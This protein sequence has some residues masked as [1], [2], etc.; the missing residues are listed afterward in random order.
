MC[1]KNLLEVNRAAED[2]LQLM[3]QARITEALT[4]AA[5][6]GIPLK[7]RYEHTARAMVAA[8]QALRMKFAASP[9]YRAEFLDEP[10]I[11][12]APVMKHMKML[13]PLRKTRLSLCINA[14]VFTP[15]LCSETTSSSDDS[16]E[17]S[18]TDSSE[19]VDAP[20]EPRPRLCHLGDRVVG[21]LNVHVPQDGTPT[22]YYINWCN[23]THDNLLMSGEEMIKAFGNLECLRVGMYF[24]C[25][26]AHVPEDGKIHPSGA[27]PICVPSPKNNMGK[28]RRYRQRRTSARPAHYSR[29]GPRSRRGG[30]PGPVSYR[31]VVAAY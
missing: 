16:S 26:V 14:Q 18:S 10:V 4:D 3:R 1:T 2:H 28:R 24:Q 30:R 7:S 25:T 27:D 29:S 31:S 12:E 13:H 5:Q 6:V 11:E 15:S 23:R 20:Q 17:R 21:R 9:L 22:K 8:L 19:V